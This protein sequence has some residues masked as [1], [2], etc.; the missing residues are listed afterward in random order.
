MHE[1]RDALIS[2]EAGAEDI[3]VKKTKKK[4]KPTPT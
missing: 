1:I 3:T 2:G 4:E